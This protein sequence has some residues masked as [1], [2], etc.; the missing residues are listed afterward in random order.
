MTAVSYPGD[1]S[2]IWRHAVPTVAILNI[3]VHSCTCNGYTSK[4]ASR[5][6]PARCTSATPSTRGS[7]MLIGTPWMHGAAASQLIGLHPLTLR[8]T[9]PGRRQGGGGGSIA[10]RLSCTLQGEAKG[11][12]H[13]DV[14]VRAACAAQAHPVIPCTPQAHLVTPRTPQAHPVVPCTQQAHLRRLRR[15]R[16]ELCAEQR[17]RRAGNRLLLLQEAAARQVVRKQPRWVDQTEQ[18]TAQAVRRARAGL[19][20]SGSCDLCA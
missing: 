12:A 10:R 15:Q 3:V 8:V 11:E 14:C 19:W 2:F 4:A 13:R 18:H 6:S 1:I 20:V 5:S 9:A 7:G 17:A 16:R